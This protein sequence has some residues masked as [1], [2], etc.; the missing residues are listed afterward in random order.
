MGPSHSDNCS[1]VEDAGRELGGGER[2]EE[3]G[4]PFNL[5]LTF[6]SARAAT[7]TSLLVAENRECFAAT[8]E[9]SS[10]VSSWCARV[11]V[12]SC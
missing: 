5:G 11:D 9:L 2:E 6:S 10:A 8:H 4:R 12:A 7:G 3:G 1:V